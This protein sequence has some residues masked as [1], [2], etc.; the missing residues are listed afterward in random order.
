MPDEEYDV[1]HLAGLIAL[2]GLP[3]SKKKNAL[4]GPWHVATILSNMMRNGVCANVAIASIWAEFGKDPHKEIKHK[5]KRK[6]RFPT[7]QWLFRLFGAISPE[8]M[9][10]RCDLMLNAQ[11]KI[12]RGAGMMTEAVVDIVDVHNVPHYGSRL[13]VLYKEPAIAPP[14]LPDR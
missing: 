3:F 8:E 13:L 4:F 10:E 7:D 2:V 5:G 9:E 6:T 12:M 1:T 11:M 14:T